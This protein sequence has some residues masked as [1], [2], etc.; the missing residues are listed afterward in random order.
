LAIATSIVSVMADLSR[1]TTS[2]NSITG[3]E[4][5][6]IGIVV[7]IVAA[8]SFLGVRW[9]FR[10]DRRRLRKVLDSSSKDP[11]VRLAGARSTY[12]RGDYQGVCKALTDNKGARLLHA[13]PAENLLLAAACYQ[14]GGFAG[15]AAAFKAALDQLGTDVDAKNA[16]IGNLPSW[17]RLIVSNLA[18]QFL[19]ADS[20]IVVNV[21]SPAGTEQSSGEPTSLGK[22]RQR[23]MREKSEAEN[24]A[25]WWSISNVALGA[26][27]AALA[28]GAGGLGP[29]LKSNQWV[30]ALLG[31]GSAALSTVLITLK[32]A[33]SAEVA[34][35]NGLKAQIEVQ[36]RLRAAKNRPF[37]N[38]LVTSS[39]SGSDGN[40]RQDPGG[41]PQ[42]LGGNGD[43]VNSPIA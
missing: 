38:P 5:F 29:V 23:V 19:E 4:W 9:L 16:A 42:D 27:S 12:E 37:P 40:N 13:L 6:A 14:L 30:I 33:E 18:E 32:P 1:P 36:N 34:K 25:Q 11:T 39:G 7:G 2:S 17:A 35:K 22:L 3:L 24:K 31:L 20:G 15:S 43:E 21:K 28:A 26:V 10:R 8:A 41:N